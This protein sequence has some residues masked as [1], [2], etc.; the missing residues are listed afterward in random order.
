MTLFSLILALLLE[1]WWPLDA[2]KRVVPPLR[3]LTDLLQARLNNGQWLHGA[4][5]WLAGV[6]PLVVLAG[7]VAYGLSR[8]SPLLGVLWNVAVLYATM[9]FRRY[10]DAFSEIAM[11]LRMGELDRARHLIGEWRGRLADL[12]S[13]ND[14]ARLAIEEGLLASHRSLFGVLFWFVVLPGPC[15]AVLYRMAEFFHREWGTREDVEFG[16]FGR[17]AKQAFEVLDW[18]PVRITAVF[19]AVA[20]D[21]EDAVY[22]WREQ[23]S[24][25]PDT[26]SAIL[27]ASGAG[28]LGVRLG[29]PVYE[30]GEIIE[31]PELGLGDE[32]DPDFMQSTIGLIWRTLV[33]CLVLL[34]LF[35]VGSWVGN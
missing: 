32:A 6:V 21:F 9:G 29:M 33:L 7:A 12:C 2:K 4:V 5:A 10:S 23:A 1:Q 24:R 17:F 34:L 13:S 30:S 31:R 19:F 27:L 35:W 25:W 26:S 16:A 11:A 14:V 8:I 3:W 18:L 28:A 15:G 22:C 20:G